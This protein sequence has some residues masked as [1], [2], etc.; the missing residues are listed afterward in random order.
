MKGPNIR[1]ALDVRRTWVCPKCGRRRQAPGQET[2]Q[3]CRCAGNGPVVWMRLEEPMRA[4]RPVR[5]FAAPQT[6]TADEAEARMGPDPNPRPVEP[7]PPAPPMN[8]AGA[9][10]GAS[11]DLAVTMTDA[12]VPVAPPDV[13]VSDPSSEPSGGRRQGTARPDRGRH[14][15]GPRTSEAGRVGKGDAP[16][17]PHRQALDVQAAVPEGS[18]PESPESGPR[19]SAPAIVPESAPVDDGFGEGL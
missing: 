12:A 6:E 15:R 5:T 7:P 1:H 17:E 10:D 11:A 9:T 2:Q 16:R 14:E 4:A 3:T 19:P 13:T 18:V 8:S